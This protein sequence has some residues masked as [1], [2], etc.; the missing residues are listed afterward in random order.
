[1]ESESCIRCALKIGRGWRSGGGAEHA[2]E[3]VCR[4]RIVLMWA[5]GASVTEIIRATSKTKRTTYRWRDRCLAHG[6]TG[7]PADQGGNRGWTAR[8]IERVVNMTLSEKPPGSTHWSL[9]KMAKAFGLSHSSVQR[10]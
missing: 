3:M 8:R 10:I 1:M 2:A 7:P 6:V 5:Q 4:A 9:R